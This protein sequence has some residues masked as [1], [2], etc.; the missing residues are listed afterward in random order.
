MSNILLVSATKLE[1]NYS[2]LFGYP[3][4]IVG[5]GK[6]ESGF[7]I[8]R[9]LNE[10]RPR[11]VINFGSCGNLKNHK[12]GQILEVGEVINDFYADPIY[13]YDSIILGKSNIKC[14][15]T[16]TFYINS[17]NYHSEYIKNIIKCDIVDMELY[18]IAHACKNYNIKLLSYKW[19][20]DDGEIDNWRETADLGFNNFK[21]LLKELINN[22]A[23]N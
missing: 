3:I 19:V 20:S 16:D 14:F 6:V 8:N 22:K 7:N 18:S 2:N 4:K 5:I 15:T 11:I 12:P 21:K 23:F 17:D 1:H 10:C 13:S 9:I